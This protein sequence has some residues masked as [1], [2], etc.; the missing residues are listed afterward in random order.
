MAACYDIH[1]ISLWLAL[2]MVAMIEFRY[3]FGDEVY[4]ALNLK[5]IS[6]KIAAIGD[7]LQSVVKKRLK[8]IDE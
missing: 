7:T 3:V 5:Q 8:V 6:V 4:H 2:H 1:A